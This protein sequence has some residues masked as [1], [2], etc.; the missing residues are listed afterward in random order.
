MSS[1]TLLCSAAATAALIGL[2]TA[3]EASASKVTLIAGTYFNTATYTNVTGCPD[4]LF[5][6]GQT[7]T[8]YFED[9][10]PG[11]TGAVVRLASSSQ[12]GAIVTVLTYAPPMLAAGQTVW[13]GSATGVNEPAGTSFNY[14]FKSVFTFVDS[15]SYLV[16][17]TIN[18]QIPSFPNCTTKSTQ[19]GVYTGQ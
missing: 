4:G 16:K 19:A 11:R 15:H 5:T 3:T 9:P 12:D 7:T 13:S 17:Q 1:R 14:T 8:S 10:G 6:V 18:W 2:L